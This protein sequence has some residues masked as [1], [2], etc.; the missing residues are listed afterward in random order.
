[1]QA[2][3]SGRKPKIIVKIL[4]TVLC[5]AMIYGSTI[6]A[7]IFFCMPFSLEDCNNEIGWYLMIEKEKQENGW[8]STHPEQLK[9]TEPIHDRSDAIR[10]HQQIYGVYTDELYIYLVYRDRK[11]D[12]WKIEA[13]PYYA[14]LN[15]M[16]LCSYYRMY[17]DCQQDA[18]IRSD[19]TI[20]AIYR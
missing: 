17:V 13:A 16:S 4:I 5:L 14:T 8:Y 20:I 6:L 19:G 1:M 2:K 9:Q 15:N 11:N 12:C 3:K 18:I 7:R 10:A